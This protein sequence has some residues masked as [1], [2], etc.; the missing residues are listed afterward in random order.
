MPHYQLPPGWTWRM[1][2]TSR[3]Q[4]DISERFYPVVT[5]PG[6]CTGWGRPLGLTVDE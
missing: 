6:V 3:V 2:V 4:W 1:V 5:L